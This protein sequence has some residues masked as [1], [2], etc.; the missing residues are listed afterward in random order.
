KCNISGVAR[1]SSTFLLTPYLRSR[2]AIML[3][4]RSMSLPDYLSLIVS[5]YGPRIRKGLLKPSRNPKRLYQKAGC[6]YKPKNFVPRSEVWIAFTQLARFLN[7]SNCYLFAVLL[8]MD[9]KKIPLLNNSNRFFSGTPVRDRGGTVRLWLYAERLFIRKQ[10]WIRKLG[11][12]TK[13]AARLL[14]ESRSG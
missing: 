1:T 13:K 10:E 5:R 12:R 11:R 7:W 9:S 2:L 3:R 4:K 8:Q 6:G 14:P